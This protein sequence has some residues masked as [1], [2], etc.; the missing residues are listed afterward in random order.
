MA[1]AILGGAIHH[2]ER[3]AAGAE[4]GASPLP[5]SRRS[6]GPL[7]AL[8]DG[9]FW[10]ALRPFFGALAAA[11][12]A[13]RRAGPRSSAV[14]RPLQRHPPR[15]PDPALPGRLPAR[16]TRSSATSPARA[17]PSPPT[18]SARRGAALCGRRGR[19]R[20]RCAG[21]PLRRWSPASSP[22]VAAAAGYVALARGARLL[23]TAYVAALVGV[24]AA[25]RGGPTPREQ[26]GHAEAERTFIIVNTLGLHARAAAQLVQIANRFRAEIHVEKDGTQ[27]NGKSI[28]GVL[29][30]AAAKGS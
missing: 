7:A 24:G 15:A 14:A 25:V 16:A 30:L 17:S 21:R 10:T 20:R 27:V 19:A 5:T 4:P 11:R 2:E 3:V 9:F 18:G 29:T 8:G 6:R 28:M 26:L 23:P 12:G 1:A 13:A 22:R